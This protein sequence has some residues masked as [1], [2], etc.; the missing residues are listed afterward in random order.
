MN[1]AADLAAALDPVA[2]RER[3]GPT[4]SVGRVFFGSGGGFSVHTAG[5]ANRRVRVAGAPRA[6]HTHA[7][8][9]RWVSHES[10]HISD[11]SVAVRPAT[12]R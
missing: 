8:Y 9:I 2:S 1:L 10:R 5:G 3:R 7:K 4:P 11:H 6:A 12:P